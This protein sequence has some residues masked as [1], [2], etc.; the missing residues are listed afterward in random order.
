MFNFLTLI[1]ILIWAIGVTFLMGILVMPRDCK[2]SF[3]NLWK[4]FGFGYAVKFAVFLVTAVPLIKLDQN[5]HTLFFT[6]IGIMGALCVLSLILRFKKIFEYLRFWVDVDTYGPDIPVAQTEA[7]DKSSVSSQTALSDES[8]MPAQSAESD[9]SALIFIWILR[10]A[11]CLLIAFQVYLYTGMTHMDT[12]DSRF[13]AEAMEAVEQGTILK[14]HPLTGE[15]LGAPIDEMRKDILS[16]YPFY[17]ATLSHVFGLPV[18]VAAHAV[19]PI[20]LLLLCYGILYVIGRFFFKDNVE[21]TWLFL[22]FVCFIHLFGFESIYATGY[23]LLT[24][25]WQGRSALLV[26]L[27]P[28][29]WLCLMRL[30]EEKSIDL[31]AVIRYLC[32]MLACLMTSGMGMTVSLFLALGYLAAS[33]FTVKD[34]RRSAIILAGCIPA[35][36]SVVMFL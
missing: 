24:I 32:V 19:L 13:I 6:Y 31:Y 20:E 17:L 28:L 7:S 14:H 2:A 26:T 1:R 33:F 10:I 21:K 22:L 16:P 34:I 5:F 11:V 15:F 25:I 29:E 27:L 18:A 30:S 9:K 8:S 35:V 23:T 4:I 36:I 12:D 3:E